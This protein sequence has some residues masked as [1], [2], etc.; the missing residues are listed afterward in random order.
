MLEMK[1]RLIGATLVL[2]SLKFHEA[3]ELCDADA[4]NDQ[5]IEEP[6]PIDWTLNTLEQDDPKL[7]KTLKDKYLVPRP[8]QNKEPLNIRDQFKSAKAL[9]GQFGQAYAVD[10]IFK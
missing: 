3:S 7:I 6:I 10:D 8:D 4:S 2:I 1:I 5:S 9:G